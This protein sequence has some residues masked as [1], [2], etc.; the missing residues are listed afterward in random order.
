VGDEVAGSVDGAVMWHVTVTVGGERTDP[1][2]VRAALERLSLER[3]FL[4]TARYAADRAEVRYWEEARDIDDAA[5]L[6]L[7]LWGEHR[8]TAGLPPWRVIGLEV[9]DRQTWQR[10]VGTRALG[11]TLTPA[12]EVSPF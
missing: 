11:H 3:P 1:R 12:G 2:E 8:A 10:R 9:I 4:L 5:A 6:A 7:R